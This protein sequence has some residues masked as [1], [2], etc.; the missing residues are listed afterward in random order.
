MSG[1]GFPVNDGEASKIEGVYQ[2]LWQEFIEPMV[3]AWNEKLKEKENKEEVTPELEVWQDEKQVF[4]KDKDN[5]FINKLDPKTLEQLEVAKDLP[6]G[7]KVEGLK[8]FAVISATSPR[9]NQ[10]EILFATDKDGLIT[11][12]IRNNTMVRGSDLISKTLE[13]VGKGGN[14]PE[15]QFLSQQVAELKQQLQEQQKVLNT[16]FQINQHQ[17]DINKILFQRLKENQQLQKARMQ[18]PRDPNWWQKGINKFDNLKE[19]YQLRRQEQMVAKTLSKLW[20]KNTKK[21][22]GIYQG[23]D[24]TMQKDGDCYTLKNKNNEPIFE[25]SRNRFSNDIFDNKLSNKDLIEIEKLKNNLKNNQ[26]DGKFA[27]LSNKLKVRNSAIEKIVDSFKDVAQRQPNGVFDKKGKDYRVNAKA[28]GEINI[29]RKEEL[30]YQQSNNGIINKME[31]KDISLFSKSLNNF[32]QTKQQ[33]LQ[34][35]Q[36]RQQTAT[37]ESVI[38]NLPIGR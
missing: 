18:S 17:R 23:E 25:Y 33:I 1:V 21:G 14:N 19:I 7:S 16:Q 12:N 4:G 38:K 3:K 31:N 2:K 26:L 13:K 30:I 8:N 29:W 10:P 9:R 6:V 5:K 37:P 24:Y 28:N 34:K 32:K 22:A 27:S 35:Q 11:K 36:Q 20:D 15:I